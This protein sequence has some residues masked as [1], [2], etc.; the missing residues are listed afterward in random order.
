MRLPL[1][2]MTSLLLGVPGCVPSTTYSP[3][4]EAKNNKGASEKDLVSI[5]C[6]TVAVSVGERC[7]VPVM[8]KNR[9]KAN[10]RVPLKGVPATTSSIISLKVW[11][12]GGGEEV[13]YPPSPYTTKFDEPDQLPI[14]LLGRNDGDV[15]NWLSTW[16]IPWSPGEYEYT[17]TVENNVREMFQEMLVRANGE[18]RFVRQLQPIP[19]V[20]V[21][22]RVNSVR[23]QIL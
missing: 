13:S 11:K 22:S 17:L 18:T 2:V 8:F 23:N 1:H 12:T 5:T 6:G 7:V 21:V 20:W 19:N 3:L 4:R 15:V 14:L 16:F 9:G 10:L